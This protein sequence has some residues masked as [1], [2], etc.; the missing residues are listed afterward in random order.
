MECSI[1]GRGG[2]NGGGTGNEADERFR[3]G[4]GSEFPV[5]SHSPAILFGRRLVIDAVCAARLFVDFV[6]SFRFNVDF[7]G[8]DDTD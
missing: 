7:F 6:P 2:G 8:R 3:R 1:F 5:E 4:N